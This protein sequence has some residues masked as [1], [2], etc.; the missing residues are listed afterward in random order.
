MLSLECSNLVLAVQSKEHELVALFVLRQVNRSPLRYW[1]VLRI[2]FGGCCW[3]VSWTSLELLTLL[4]RC[5]RLDCFGSLN[6]NRTVFFVG[7]TAVNNSGQDS[8][9]IFKGNDS[10]KYFRTGDPDRVLDIEDSK[11]FLEGDCGVLGMGSTDCN[12]F[13]HGKTGLFFKDLPSRGACAGF[14]SS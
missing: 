5:R 14:R 12:I 6:S 11:M 9:I 13:M 1:V 4:A 8:F 7:D 2:G 3:P 10:R